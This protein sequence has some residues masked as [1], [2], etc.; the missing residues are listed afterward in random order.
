MSVVECPFCKKPIDLFK[1]SR[2]EKTAKELSVPFVGRIPTDLDVVGASDRWIPLVLLRPD[3][4]VA[5]AFKAVACAIKSAI[6]AGC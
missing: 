5:G 1:I 4:E 6:S 3:S 2:G